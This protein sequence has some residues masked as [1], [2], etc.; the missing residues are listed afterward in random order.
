[1][2]VYFNTWSYPKKKLIYISVASDRE[3]VL[4]INDFTGL[5]TDH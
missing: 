3:H 2:I 5:D 1:M 4:L